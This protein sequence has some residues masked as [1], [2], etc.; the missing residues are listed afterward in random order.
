MAVL[1]QF[2]IS[3]SGGGVLKDRKIGLRS[4]DPDGDD[5]VS[6][7]PTLTCDLSGITFANIRLNATDETIGTNTYT[8]GRCII[9]DVIAASNATTGRGHIEYRY[10]TV[11]GDEL[12]FKVPLVVADKIA[13]A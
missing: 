7:T 11:N 9:F 5:Y 12:A 6:A 3:T 10:E 1:R 4:I 8:P 2:D 13:H